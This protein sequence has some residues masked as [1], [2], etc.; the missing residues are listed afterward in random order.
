LLAAAVLVPLGAG[1][2]SAQSTSNAYWAGHFTLPLRTQ[3]VA[4]ALSIERRHALVTLG[5]G[6]AWTK[7]VPL[8]GSGGAFAFRLPGRPAPLVF[9]GRV[10][11]NVVTGVLRQGTA[12]GTFRLTR[13]VHPVRAF[14][15][16]YAF[17]PGE[18]VEIAD[19]RRL[20]APLWAI[21]YSTG[22]FHALSGSEPNLGVGPTVLSTRPRVGRITESPERLG[23]S[24]VGKGM[25][26]PVSQYEVRFRSGRT[27]LAGT[28]SIPATPGRH[29]AAAL[30]HGSGPALRDEGQFFTGLMLEHG[31][32]VLSY[33]KR[34]IGESGGTYPG[35]K[36]RSQAVE[37]YARDAQAAVRFLSHQPKVD[38]TRLG[39]LGGSQAGW[40]IPLAAA[41]SSLVRF[42]IIQSGPTVT[43]GQSDE[44]EALTGAGASPLPEPLPQIE[45]QVEHDGPSGF[46]PRPWIAKLRI[47]V[48]WL[49]GGLDMNQPTDLDVK[50]LEQ[51]DVTK[52]HDF[53]WHVYPNGNHGIFD[54][55]TGL[56]SELA[57]S[58]G[59]PARFFSDLSA[60]LETHGLAL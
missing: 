48:L 27:T 34:G 2:A 56:T 59:M 6:H 46:D 8:A 57:S 47:P 14:L 5:P 22:A 35:E 12:R 3:P 37:A 40:I 26:L 52:G 42:A 20:G 13:A 49:Y 28:L 44:F 55:K 25:R 1:G 16:A 17:G 54:V 50:A 19:Y 24:G 18:V 32:A 10:D 45:A 60:W 7:R 21:D 11:G 38:R 43:V 9:R 31:I 4:L 58:P 41:R 53:T 30:V 39:L 15:G 33:D 36:A 51:L 29:P 23:W